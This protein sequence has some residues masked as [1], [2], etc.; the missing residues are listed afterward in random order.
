MAKI[1][2]ETDI[3]NVIKRAV[4]EV[5][6]EK[7]IAT[8]KDVEDIVIDAI[9]TVV[10]P[11][12]DSVAEDIKSELGTKIDFLDR[13]FT[14]QQNRLDKHNGRIEKLE[15]IHPQGRHLATI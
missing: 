1:K 10:I 4:A 7:Q 8:K 9:N 13:K 2:K 5:I 11:G 3:L 14:S 6:D 12:I 15:R